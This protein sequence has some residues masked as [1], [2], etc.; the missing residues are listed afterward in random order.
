MNTDL[1]IRPIALPEPKLAHLAAEA[2]A[3]GFGFV[4]RLIADGQTSQNLFLAPG[5]KLLG[6]FQG[7]ELIAVGGLNHDPY[8]VDS[9]IGRLR[10]IY[11]RPKHR[12]LRV[13]QLLV[14]MLLKQAGQ[15]FRK[16][17]LRTQTE[18]AGRFYTTLGF[19]TSDEDDATH[20]I[21]LEAG[22]RGG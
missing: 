7:E 20:E 22:N 15:H 2:R 1:V 11:V 14:S 16:V 6:V 19:V 21:V 4:E 17:R 8:V 5:E 13:G 18:A 3:E 10:H 9:S 12:E